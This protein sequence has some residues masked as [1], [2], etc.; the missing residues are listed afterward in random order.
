LTDHLLSSLP[1][2]E[3]LITRVGVVAGMTAAYVLLMVI[4]PGLMG[5]CA[6]AAAAVVLVSAAGYLLGP[7]GGVLVPGLLFL[8]NTLLGSEPL[9]P[10]YMRPVLYGAGALLGGLVGC[11]TASARKF[12][13]ARRELARSEERLWTILEHAPVMIQAFTADGRCLIW[14]R[15]LARRNG[16]TRAEAERMNLDDILAEDYAGEPE[17]ARRA[18][19]LWREADGAF[20]E[21]KPRTAA[22]DRPVRMWASYRLSDGTTISLGYDVSELKRAE[23]RLRELVEEKQS[24]LEQARDRVRSSIQIVSSLL[25]FQA[26]RFEDGLVRRAL[27]ESRSR[28]RAVA[29]AH[30]ELGRSLTA[31]GIDMD[32]HIRRIVAELSDL[33]GGRGRVEVQVEAAGV[34]LGPEGALAVSLIVNEL[35]SN[36]FEHAFSGQGGGRGE[37]GAAGRILVRLSEDPEAGQ[38][39][40]EVSDNG[41]GPPADLDVERAGTL[42]MILVRSLAETDLRGSIRLDRTEGTRWI[43][44]FP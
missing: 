6:E 41:T 11:S 33:H 19:R 8:L 20:H 27:E 34:E 24:L 42:G 32:R 37:G 1:Y 43:V 3:P 2:P 29:M 30:E 16:R 26:R 31:S 14:N 7:A 21:L 40:L 15:E 44:R 5:S 23:A 28:L 17:Q 35:V 18:Y 25:M 12:E 38:W 13:R 39:T 4:F 10:P 36:S 9:L 22:G